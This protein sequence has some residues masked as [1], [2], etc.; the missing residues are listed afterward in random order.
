MKSLFYFLKGLLIAALPCF[1]YGQSAP[2]T[3][4]LANS[5]KAAKAI[6]D[7]Q[8]AGEGP[9]FNGVQYKEWI[10]HNSD[11]GHP[12][13]FSDD[14]VDG[15]ISYDGAQFENVPMMYDLVRDQVIIDQP[16]SHFK[17]QLIT[18]KVTSFTLGDHHFVHV[19]TDSTVA[20]IKPGFY[21]LLYD[22]KVKVYAKYKKRWSERFE[23]NIIR[24]VFDQ[25]IEYFIFKDNN[26]YSVK[27]KHSVLQVFSNKK[28]MLRKYLNKNKI[29]FR[30]PAIAIAQAARFY[31]ESD[32]QP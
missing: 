22:G 5:I 13:F 8:T 15:P 6:Y 9:L 27:N 7:K 14:W 17:M 1:A 3:L 21:E 29:S 11:E 28:V 31:E 12:Y 16:L 4:F 10:Q 26:Y 30:E 2:D 25:K 24:Q 23:S 18:G 32:Q 20:L 19:F